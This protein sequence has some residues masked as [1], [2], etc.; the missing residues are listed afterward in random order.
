M[1]ESFLEDFLETKIVGKNILDIGC[2]NGQIA[3]HFLQKDNQVSAVDI[4]DQLAAHCDNIDF[5]LVTCEKLP[6][7]SDTFD[8]VLSHHVIEHVE[9]QDKHLSEMI[10]VVKDSGVIYFGCP[11]KSSPFMA[12]HIGNDKVLTL[13]EMHQLFSEYYSR[14]LK[15]PGKYHC[16]IRYG[17]YIPMPIIRA[18]RIW[19]P[20]QYFILTRTP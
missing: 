9:D 15:Y 5:S 11:N 10:R 7:E 12:G 14:L 4:T 3:Q 8:I 6:F 17:K 16:E 13:R 18:L 19:Y 2:G 1:I 20:S